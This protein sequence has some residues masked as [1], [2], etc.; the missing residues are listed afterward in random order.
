MDLSAK[1]AEIASLSVED[2]ITLVEAIWDTIGTD[3]I[4][5]DLS[6]TQKQELDRRIAELDACPGNVL[7][8]DEIKARIRNSG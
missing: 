4:P 2:R 3:E 1:I 8:W 5:A 7:T 6:D